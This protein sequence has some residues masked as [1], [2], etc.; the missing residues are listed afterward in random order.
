MAAIKTIP[1]DE[2]I[3]SYISTLPN[4][5]KQKEAHFIVNLLKDITGKAPRMWGPSIIGYDVQEY[6]HGRMP[7][8]AFSPRKPKQVFYVI[9]DTKEQKDLLAQLGKYKTG[10]VCLYINKLADVDTNIL[11]KILRSSW[12]HA[13]KQNNR[14]E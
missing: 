10:K 8:I 9:N 3:K 11:E 5:R 2:S 6:K 7:M 1:T 14:E 12:K 13:L 4:E